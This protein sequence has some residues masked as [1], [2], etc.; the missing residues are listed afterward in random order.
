MAVTYD[1]NTLVG[2]VRLLINDKDVTNPVFQDEEIVS[3]LTDNGNSVNL[4][5]ATAIESW[6]AS[7]SANADSEKIGDYSYSQKTS[8]NMLALAQRLRDKDS[9]VPAA[10]WAEMDLDGDGSVE[11]ER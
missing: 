3:F 4:A 9:S 7:Y 1:L 5:A 10:G 6:A 2:K 11:G 8:A